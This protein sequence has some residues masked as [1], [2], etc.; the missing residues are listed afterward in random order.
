MA[1]TA[2]RSMH[3]TGFGPGGAGAPRT[4]PLRGRLAALR[5]RLGAGAD[6]GMPRRL[7]G[8]AQAFERAT[9]PDAPLSEQVLVE[10]QAFR[11]LLPSTLPEPQVRRDD[12]GA[13][14]FEW[15]ARETCYLRVSVEGDGMLV[16]TGR[17]G[18]K[19]RISGAEPLGRDLPVMIRQAILQLGR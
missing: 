2:D 10:A 4:G 6:L 11:R 15:T 13:L 1:K 14:A 17:L 19:R 16:Y 8:Y 5:D 3:S 18:A 9:P 12:H 7:E